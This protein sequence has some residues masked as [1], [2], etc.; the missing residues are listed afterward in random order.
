MHSVTWH[1]TFHITFLLPTLRRAYAEWNDI[2][3]SR[4]KSGHG[5]LSYCNALHMMT[6]IRREHRLRHADNAWENW[7][8]AISLHSK[9]T[10]LNGALSHGDIY[11]RWF[12]G[13]LVDWW[14]RDKMARLTIQADNY[15]LTWNFDKRKLLIYWYQCMFIAILLSKCIVSSSWIMKRHHK[16]HHNKAHRKYQ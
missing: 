4:L 8:A 13:Q 9:F 14:Q 10:A 2:L 5:R 12:G 6:D 7:Y 16:C 1:D 3:Y 15:R 11:G